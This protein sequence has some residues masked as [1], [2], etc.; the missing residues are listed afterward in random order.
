MNISKEDF[1]ILVV[2][3]AR[4]AIGR[5][6]TAPSLVADIAT[7]YKDNLEE[8]TKNVIIDEVGVFD[9]PQSLGMGQDVDTWRNLVEGL[10]EWEDKQ[11]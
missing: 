3:A 8:Q 11:N 10:F 2:F 5:M 6:S 9:N 1:N 7:K 4:Y